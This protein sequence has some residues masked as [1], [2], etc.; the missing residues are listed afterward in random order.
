M[1]KFILSGLP[2]VLIMGC[3]NKP[4]EI[5]YGSR[6]FPSILPID[7]LRLR[8]ADA[9]TTES[10]AGEYSLIVFAD[11][12]CGYC[13]TAVS[14]L[15]RNSPKIQPMRIMVISINAVE[16]GSFQD[17]LKHGSTSAV[18]LIDDHLKSLYAL[19]AYPPTPSYF[20][21]RSDSLIKVLNGLQSFE[22]LKIE[23]GYEEE[24]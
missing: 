15:I 14:E 17:S 6:G 24:K 11:P 8:Y 5:D 3:L 13:R 2:A 21:Y 7:S 16:D 19:F 22:N 23:L 12:G 9:C 20:I 10:S 18:C 1:K 4:P